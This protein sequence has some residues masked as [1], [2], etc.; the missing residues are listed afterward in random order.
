LTPNHCYMKQILFVLLVAISTGAAAQKVDAK[1]HFQKGK[2]DVITVVDRT[3]TFEVMSQSMESIAKST[4]HEI[5]DVQNVSGNAII[6]EHK[7]KRLIFSAEQMGQ[8]QTFDSEKDED[9][10]GEM[11]KM[12]EKNLKDKYTMTVDNTGKIITV[13]DDQISKGK[14]DKNLEGMADMIGSQLGINLT[15]PKAGA[16][17]MF[18]ILPNK[19]IALGDA[20]VDTNSTKGISRKTMYRVN[21]I[22]NDEIILDVTEETTTAMV[23]Q[24]MGQNAN[25]NMTDKFKGRITIDK[26]TGLLK[27]RTGT[28]VSEGT[29]EAQGMTIP[30]TAKTSITTTVKPE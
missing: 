26:K 10:K 8:N 11:G 4:T 23:Q 5:L 2:L 13:T 29:V 17:S 30:M 20:W 19:T 15:I 27:K 16:Y 12:I 24:M 14:N 25:V 22:T 28:S 21:T 6:I 9:R 18:K 3:S 7:L 1:L